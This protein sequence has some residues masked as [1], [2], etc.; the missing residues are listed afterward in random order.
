MI[1]RGQTVHNEFLDLPSRE[2]NP[3][4]YDLVQH[5]ISLNLIKQ[6]IDQDLYDDF[7]SFE[8]DLQLLVNNARTVSQSGSQNYACAI[9]IQKILSASKEEQNEDLENPV[10]NFFSFSFSFFFFFFFLIIIILH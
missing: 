1:C 5:P 2:T 4:Y 9:V 7:S 10:K 3:K 6:K 8:F